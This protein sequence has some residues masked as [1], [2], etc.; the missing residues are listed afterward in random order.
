M[1]MVAFAKLPLDELR[2]AFERTPGC[3]VKSIKAKTPEG[4]DVSVDSIL[5]ELEMDI[6]IS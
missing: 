4:Q 5:V 1:K 2:K 3:V 6:P